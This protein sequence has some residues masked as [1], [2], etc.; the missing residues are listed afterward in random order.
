MKKVEEHFPKITFTTYS[1]EEPC[2]TSALPQILKSL[3]FK[4]AVL[5]NPNTC[6]GGY[7]K[8]YGGESL[9]WIGPDGTSILTVPRYSSEAFQKNSTWQTIAWNN[10]KNYIDAALAQGIKYPVGMCI[11]DAGWKNGPWL[12]NRKSPL[13]QYT[14]WRNYFI[15]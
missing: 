8:A 10:S 1:S 13:T 5:K 15:K 7:V 4:Y 12:G 2:F 6:W 9:N 3:G 11:Q 14:T